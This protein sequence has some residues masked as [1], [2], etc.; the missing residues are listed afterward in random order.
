M[1]QKII[2]ILTTTFLGGF[3]FAYMDSL[4]VG[5]TLHNQ[6]SPETLVQTT[7]NEDSPIVALDVKYE[8]QEASFKGYGT[9]VFIS[10][11][12]ILTAA[13]VINDDKQGPATYVHYMHN[14]RH[15][16]IKIEDVHYYRENF[17][18]ADADDLV[19]LKVK[20]STPHKSYPVVRQ[21]TNSQIKVIGYPADLKANPELH[22]GTPYEARGDIAYESNG[23]WKTTAYTLK[24][25]SGAPLLNANNEV[26]GIHVGKTELTDV[27]QVSKTFSLSVKFT[28]GQLNWINKMIETH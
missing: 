27:L 10:D 28:S 15:N 9:G 5:Q 23:M 7:L 14:G 1:F 24:G 19:I 17:K 12:T 20:N 21:D 25:M 6:N 3:T 11:D 8:K 4:T 18:S 22:I 26:I 2:M 16:T 13:H